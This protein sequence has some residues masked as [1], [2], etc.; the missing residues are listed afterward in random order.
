M[1]EAWHFEYSPGLLGVEE[2]RRISFRQSSLAKTRATKRQSGDEPR[3]KG[4]IRTTGLLE[5]P[6]WLHGLRTKCCLCEDAGLIPGLTQWVKDLTLLQGRPQ[7]Q[8]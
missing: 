2:G 3:V 5:F 6:L 7:I 1:Q 8:L 4:R